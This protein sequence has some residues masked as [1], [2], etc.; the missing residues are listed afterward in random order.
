MRDCQDWAASHGVEVADNHIFADR[1]ITGK[2]HKRAGLQALLRAL[3]DD[4]IDVVIVFTTNRLFRKMYKALQ[5]IEEEVVDRQKRCVFVRQAIDTDDA[6]LWRPLMQVFA[7]LDE[8]QVAMLAA[9]VHSAH[10]GLLLKGR[11]HGTITF[12]YWAMP[13]D[14]P[15]TRLGKPRTAWAIHEESAAWVRRIFAWFTGS[16]S[17]EYPMNCTAIAKRLNREGAPPPPRSPYGKWSAMAV[18]IVLCNRRYIGDW[19][20]ARSKLVWQ[21]KAGYSKQVEREAPLREHLDPSLRIIGDEIFFRAQELRQN[22]KGH[23][24]RRRKSAQ[25]STLPHLFERLLWCPAHNRFLWKG[26]ANGRSYFCPECR[27]SNSPA[28]FSF[29]SRHLAAKIICTKVADLILGDETLVAQIVVCFQTQLTAIMNPPADAKCNFEAENARLS[30]AISY[31]L[32][33]PAA[34]ESDRKEKYQR[35][36]RLQSERA[37]LEVQMKAFEQ[38]KSEANVQIPTSS[39]VQAR[40]E[41]LASILQRAAHS[42]DLRIIAAAHKI[43]KLVTGGRITMSQQGEAAARRGWLRAAFTVDVLKAA[44]LPGNGEQCNATRVELDLREPEVD[45]ALARKAKAMFD[46]GLLVKQ[47]AKTLDTNR[48]CIHNLLL[49]AFAEVGEQLPDGRCRRARLAQKHV[50]PTLRYQLAD[51]A[52]ALWDSGKH[53]GAIAA[54]LDAD[55]NTITAALRFWFESRGLPYPD[56]RTRRKS[57]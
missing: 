27:R 57:L 47:I 52:K 54:A 25:G 48:N 3:D 9:F 15:E 46:E 39:Q 30:S 37:A 16:D 29:A 53:L 31:I 7:M 32:N 40:L 41:R 17:G 4:E 55:R 19:S 49:V 5:F 45:L 22:V 11:V 6:E 28:L 38:Q 43:L 18:K 42:D 56:G 51:R 33:A 20:Y 12:G 13:V 24:G 50:T 34:T 14:G 23:G 1:G 44:G 10:E 2:T 36:A 35:L 8:R 26:G 21:N